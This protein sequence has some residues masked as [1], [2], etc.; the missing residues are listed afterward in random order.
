MRRDG[1]KK[2]LLVLALAFMAGC[3]SET[4]GENTANND[5]EELK[6]ELDVPSTVQQNEDVLYEAT[7]TYGDEKVKKADTVDFEFKEANSDEE[8]EMIKAE[9]EENGIYTIKHRF[10][11]E[12]TYVVQVHVLAHSQHVMPEK[13]VKVIGEK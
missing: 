9:E 13:E 7:V 6:V 4:S 3:S 8:G 12:G 5:T 2:I 11:K 1:M 10:E